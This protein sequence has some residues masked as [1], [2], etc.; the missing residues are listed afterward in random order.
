M[1]VRLTLL[2]QFVCL[3]AIA[4]LRGKVVSVADGDTFTLLTDQKVQYKI[5]LHGIDAPEKAQDFGTVA[6]TYL[7]DLVFGKVVEVEPKDVDQYGRTIG[8]VTVD[9]KNVNEELLIAGLVWHYAYYDK[10]PLWAKLQEQAKAAKL[11]LWSMASPVA[12]WLWRRMNK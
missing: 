11:G 1:K 7:S 3:L 6:K 9:G 5:R 2:L 4:Q 8:M 10:N 12:P